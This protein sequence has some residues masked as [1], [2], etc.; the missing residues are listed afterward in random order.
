MQWTKRESNLMA[1][2]IAKGGSRVPEDLILQYCH[3][4]TVILTH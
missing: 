1:S 4:N 3:V 2:A